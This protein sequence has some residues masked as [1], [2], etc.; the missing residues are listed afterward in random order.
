M[1]PLWYLLTRWRVS[2]LSR[3]WSVLLSLLGSKAFALPIV[4]LW[5][6]RGDY[7]VSR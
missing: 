1:N 3:A 2:R 4:L 6:R 7:G 5:P